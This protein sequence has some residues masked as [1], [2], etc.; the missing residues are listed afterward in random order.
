[1]RIAELEQRKHYDEVAV[2]RLH[3]ERTRLEAE[4]QQYESTLMAATDRKSA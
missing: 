3:R 4:I 1:M 2:H